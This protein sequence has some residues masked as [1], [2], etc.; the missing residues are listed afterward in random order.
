MIGADTGERGVSYP[1]V[2][3][4]ALSGDI[5]YSVTKLGMVKETAT[6]RSSPVRIIKMPCFSRR[7]SRDGVITQLYQ[8]LRGSRVHSFQHNTKHGSETPKPTDLLR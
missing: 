7:S 2:N 8:E 3:G 5:P 6:F 4:L 1:K